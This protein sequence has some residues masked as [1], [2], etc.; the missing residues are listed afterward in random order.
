MDNNVFEVTPTMLVYGGDALARLPDGRAVFIP[1]A[2]PGELCRI[3]LVEDKDR[4]ARAELLE[5]VSESELRISPR[6]QHYMECG[7]CHYQHIDYSEQLLAKQKILVDQLKRVGKIAQPPVNKT[8]ASPSEWN[9]RNHLQFL[10]SK[11]GQPG[12]QRHRSDQIVPIH[13]CHLPEDSLNSIWPL[14]DLEFI[15][16]LDRVSLRTGEGGSD[17]LI[18]LESSDPQPMEFSVDMPLSAVLQG[19]GG[20]IILSG[21][22]FTI[23]PVHG[24]PFVV[25]AGAFFQVNTGMAEVLIDHILDLLPLNEKTVIIEVYSGV[26][27][28]S[29]FLAPN[30]K[31]LIAIESHPAACEDFLYNLSGHDNV[32]LYDMPAE[33][34]LS[35]LDI[36]PDI[37][38]VDPPRAGL[39]R[40]VLDQVAALDPDLLVYISCDPAT[41]ARDASR[42]ISHGFNLSESTPYDMFPQTYHIESLNL[43]K[44]ASG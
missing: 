20:K 8:V 30:V 34:I 32:Q 18:V 26:G 15:P 41:L 42:L 23:I 11:T 21:D 13:E 1:Y 5:V 24:F 17:S 36:K 39:S 19:P 7:G 16:G 43:F 3:R 27:L 4:F 33:D 35:Q 6:C 14:L 31:N 37:I 25:S 38:L 2:L 28:F 22:E 40:K 9:Y 44:R 29:V 12:F 10:I